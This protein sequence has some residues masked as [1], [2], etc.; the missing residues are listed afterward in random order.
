MH[1]TTQLLFTAPLLAYACWRDLSARMIPDTA[2]LALAGISLAARLSLGV[3]A[4]L[5]SLLTASLL[6]GIL[7][8]CA[9]R[10]WLGGGDVKLA[11]AVAVGMSPG[12]TWDFTFFTALAGGLLGVVYLLGPLFA[13]RLV[14]APGAGLLPRLAAVE[15]RRLRRRGPLPYGFAIAAGALAVLV[16]NLR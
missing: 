14:A 8:F 2:S 13:P 4:A 11:S 12:A 5:L 1:I 9:V 7:L 16:A 15:A 10:G 3:E 6:L